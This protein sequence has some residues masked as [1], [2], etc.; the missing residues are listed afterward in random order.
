MYIKK[1]AI[2]TSAILFVFAQAAF[3]QNSLVGKDKLVQ[4]GNT[5]ITKT[6]LDKR[7]QEFTKLSAIYGK[8][9][10]DKEVLETMI[11]EALVRKKLQ[12]EDNSIVLDE[13]MYKNQLDTMKKQFN[14]ANKK[15]NPKYA[16]SDSDFVNYIIGQGMTYE[17][18][19]K[20]LKDKVKVQQ[21]IQK[22]SQMKMAKLQNKKYDSPTDFPVKFPDDNGN[23]LDYN[24]IEDIYK[25]NADKF[26]MPGY[27]EVKHIL[28]LTIGAEGKFSDAQKADAKLKIEEAYS[29]LTQK[30]EDFNRVCLLYT[31]DIQSKA[32]IV[33]P[34]TKV[35][36]RGYLGPIPL[37]GQGALIVK[38]QF[39][40]K[41][42]P[43][44]E[45]LKRGDI[46]SI[47]EGTNG[48][49]IFYC[50]DRNEGGKRPLEKVK[51]EIV[52]YIKNIESNIIMQDTYKELI[53]GIKAKTTIT[54]FMKEYEPARKK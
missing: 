5:I 7:T 35:T 11:D 26:V 40:D 18:F 14:D 19:E 37:E 45:R 15:Q 48:Y 31:E 16:Y 41:I 34:E 47:V 38:K 33:H 21:I 51:G 9:F 30:K 43:E 12:E 54:W 29:R 46:S 39:G 17:K 53:D 32:E 4:V 27:V 10:T 28:V 3:S 1:T 44:L 49:H 42:L 23:L 24:S 36:H 6:E 8:T 20:D 2:I 13:A 22:M 52:N 50:V 25:F